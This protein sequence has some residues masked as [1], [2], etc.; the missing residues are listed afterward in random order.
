[1]YL[2]AALRMIDSSSLNQMEPSFG[3]PGIPAHPAWRYPAWELMVSAVAKVTGIHTL[4][5]FHL[6]VPFVVAILSVSAYLRLSEYLF[7]PDK[8][9]RVVFATTAV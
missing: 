2:S 4:I 1:M 7:G 3:E 6:V 9:Y 8:A 5:L